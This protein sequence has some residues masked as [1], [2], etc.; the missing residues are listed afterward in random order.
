M[1]NK[2]LNFQ[3]NPIRSCS[4]HFGR[5]LF[6]SEAFLR[7]FPAKTADAGGKMVG[8]IQTYTTVQFIGYEKHG[9]I[10]IKSDNRSKI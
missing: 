6:R 8:D 5:I 7:P 2:K 4:V 1:K 9:Y 10:L 3:T